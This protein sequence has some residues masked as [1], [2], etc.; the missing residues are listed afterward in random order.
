MIE[1]WRAI[2]NH[3]G[4]EVS[5]LGQVRSMWPDRGSK[6][7]PLEPKIIIGGF[8]QRGYRL[9]GLKP[10][11][12]ISGHRIKTRRV[13]RLV[14]E[15]FIPN[16]NQLPQVNHKDGDK[17]NNRADNLEWISNADNATHAANNNLYAAGLQSGMGKW[18]DSMARSVKCLLDGGVRPVD[19]SRVLG[20]P[21]GSLYWLAGGRKQTWTTAQ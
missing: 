12:L 15:T 17:L 18:P 7:A 14:A 19:V 9:V 3:R 21:M 20:V 13:H 4:Y 5:N 6:A 8:D 2:K 1:E 11:T 10:E 16:P